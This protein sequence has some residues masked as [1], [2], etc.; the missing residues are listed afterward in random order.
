MLP[1]LLSNL[2]N[3]IIIDSGLTNYD[4]FCRITA[5]YPTCFTIKKTCSPDADNIAKQPVFLSTHPLQR[6]AIV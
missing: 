2:T 1:F 3:Y 6:A 4:S 5:A